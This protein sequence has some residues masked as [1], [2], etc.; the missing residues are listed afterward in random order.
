MK[1]PPELGLTR[2]QLHRLLA[3]RTGHGDF[4]WYH[5]AFKHNDVNLH[6]TCGH[7]KTELHFLQCRK[8]AA[9]RDKWPLIKGKRADYLP[10]MR[11]EKGRTQYLHY[12]TSNPDAW[13]QWLQTTRFYDFIC[14]R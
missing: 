9:T 3:M 5:R 2:P 1:S 4:A 10:D 8:A 7:L 12:L 11:T 14:P 6:C 13:K